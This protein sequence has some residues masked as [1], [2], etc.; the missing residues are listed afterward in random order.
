MLQSEFN[1]F[2]EQNCS[3]TITDAEASL[4]DQGVDSLAMLGLLV[5]V[6]EDLGV[7]LDPESLANGELSTPSALFRY[8]ERVMAVAS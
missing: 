3:V 8:V 4:A 6:E 7:E 1:Q 5:A 2:I